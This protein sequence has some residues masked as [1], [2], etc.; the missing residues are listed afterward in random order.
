MNYFFLI[1]CSNIFKRKLYYYFYEKI[2]GN[3][4]GIYFGNWGGYFFV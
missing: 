4:N 3:N 2:V 1:F